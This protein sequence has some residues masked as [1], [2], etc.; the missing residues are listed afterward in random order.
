[1]SEALATPGGVFVAGQGA[2]TGF[3]TGVAPFLTALFA[4]RTAIAPRARTARYAVPTAVAAE[5]PAATLADLAPH[6]DQ[7]QD[8]A[9]ASALAAAREALAQAGLDATR[10][11]LVLAS[12][13]GDLSGVLDTGTGLGLPARLATRLAQALGCPTVLGTVS[14]ACA[15][16]LVATAMAARHLRA[17]HAQHA[18]V[19][20]VDVLHEFVVTGF[21]SLHALDPEPCR[22][23]DRQ[24]RG[25]TLGEAAGALVL[26]RDRWRSLGAELL[27]HGGAN[28]A[29]HVTG[30]DRQG[31]GL[32]LAVRRALAQAGLPPDAI[33]CV[34]VHGTATVAND[35]SEA[36]GLVSVFGRSPATFGTKAQTG[37]TLGAAGVIETIALV[38]AL[39]RGQ[40]PANQGLA[41][42]DVD[43]G[44]DLVRAPRRLPR[45]RT[46]LKV[47]SGF[48]G[49]QAALVVR[50]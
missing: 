34:H 43:P 16:G 15:S 27:G 28:D 4:G 2:V 20:G 19:L 29:C 5:F 17:G 21:G 3:G 46:G 45:A 9:F 24:R 10:T 7:T 40:A 49:V 1:M 35:S 37:H 48:G 23:F 8:L 6:Q 44:L 12:T 13:K 30:P 38:A 41:D 22:P 50:T 36:L 47:A 32:A 26:T 25:V 33:D 39:Q 42:P 11:P 14:T 18:L 31:Q